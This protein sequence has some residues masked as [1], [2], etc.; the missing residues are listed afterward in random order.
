MKKHLVML[1]IL[2]AVGFSAKVSASPVNCLQLINAGHKNISVELH[3]ASGKNATV[4]LKSP[5]IDLSSLAQKSRASFVAN[6]SYSPEDKI[7]SID[8]I[9]GGKV[10][11]TLKKVYKK[12]K[13]APIEEV[14]AATCGDI[15]I[16]SDEGK[17]YD[18]Y[19]M[20]VPCGCGDENILTVDIL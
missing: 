6:V 7:T 17:T 4:D 9:V 20:F 18:P 5:K 13:M 3:T 15:L 14:L 8:V 2:L 19:L 10:L 16:T 1:M 12:G 11:K